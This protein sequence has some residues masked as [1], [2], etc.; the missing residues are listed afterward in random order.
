ME[1]AAIAMPRRIPHPGQ[2]G[3]QGTRRHN[4]DLQRFSKAARCFYPFGER[5]RSS[6]FDH[7]FRPLHVRAHFR[8]YVGEI[9]RLSC[10][11]R[12]S[13]RLLEWDQSDIGFDRF[14]VPA[15]EELYSP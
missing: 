11:G 8:H 13:G 4:L 6:L 14:S 3:R 2:G 1:N 7:R 10:L 12:L 9:A 15:P 5:V